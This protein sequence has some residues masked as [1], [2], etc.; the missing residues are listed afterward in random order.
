MS[1]PYLQR[2]ALIAVVSFATLQAC[3]REA[4]LPSPAATASQ[5]AAVVTTTNAQSWYEAGIAPGKHPA[6][7]I[8]WDKAQVIQAGAEEHLIVPIGDTQDRFAASP[9]R[10]Y[11]R[12]IIRQRNSQP[13]EGT[14][15]ELLVQRSEQQSDLEHVFHDLYLAQRNKERLAPPELSG[16]AFFYTADYTYLTGYRYSHGRAAAESTTLLVKAAPAQLKAGRGSASLPGLTAMTN[17]EEGPGPGFPGNPDPYPLDP[18]TVSPPPSPP[19]YDPFPTPTPGPSNPTD[20]FPQPTSPDPGNGDWGGGGGYIITTLPGTVTYY[21]GILAIVKFNTTRGGIQAN[22]IEATLKIENGNVTNVI[23]HMYGLTAG[24]DFVQEDW[25]QNS[26]SN[27][28]YYFS[29][30]FHAA[31]SIPIFGIGI[32]GA[33]Q[34]AIAHCSYN[35]TTGVNSIYYTRK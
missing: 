26:K 33:D 29:F 9:Y 23:A 5:S 10:A 24:A 35:P 2:A 12:L 8:Y 13:L 18:I 16:A 7:P 25:V 17:E 30:A 21:D 6:L 22:F 28:T 19:P 14:I 32:L 4:D 15:V 31:Y 34:T 20:P 1:H 3:N 27:G 11:R